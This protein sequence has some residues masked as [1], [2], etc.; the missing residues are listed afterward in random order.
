MLS[1]ASFTYRL[2]MIQ[3]EFSIQVLSV[4]K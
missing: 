4:H 1:A 3:T 2:V